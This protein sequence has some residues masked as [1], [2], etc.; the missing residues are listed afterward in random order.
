[1]LFQTSTRKHTK[2]VNACKNKKN[3]IVNTCKNMQIKTVNSVLLFPP[4]VRTAIVP[5]FWLRR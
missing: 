5:C 3:K 2:N 4:F 1:M